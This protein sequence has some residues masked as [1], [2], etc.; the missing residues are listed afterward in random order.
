MKVMG[1]EFRRNYIQWESGMHEGF[2]EEKG[3]AS[4]QRRK[5]RS[6]NRFDRFDTNW[7][8]RPRVF[9]DDRRRR[10]VSH[11]RGGSTTRRGYILDYKRRWNPSTACRLRAA[12]NQGSNQANDVFYI[13]HFSKDLELIDLRKGL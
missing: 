13:T 9:D 10:F 11:R 4:G 5:G 1:L 3:Y 12:V 2:G 7:D 6:F 8:S